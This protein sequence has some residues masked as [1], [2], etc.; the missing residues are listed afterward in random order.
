MVESKNGFLEEVSSLEKKALEKGFLFLSL[1]LLVLEQSIKSKQIQLKEEAQ[2]LEKY[3]SQFDTLEYF[4][5]EQIK[6]R[7][8]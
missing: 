5:S 3:K 2:N 4:Q 6:N 7:N 1:N 8:K